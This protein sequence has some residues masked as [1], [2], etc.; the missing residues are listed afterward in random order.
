MTPRGRLDI[1]WADLASGA[2]ASLLPPSREALEWRV[3]NAWSEAADA[4]VCL[5]VRSGLDLLLSA[6]A[7]PR[8]SE[9]LVSAVTIRDMVR[10]I[11]HHGLVPVP[12]DLDM[13][14]L[15]VR[16]ESLE[17]ALRPQTKAVLV[18]HLF[19]S[20]MC[21]DAVAEFTRRH[22]LLL[23][24]DCAQSFT[25]LD[26]RGHPASDVTMFS[27]GPIKT[28]T[29]LGGAILGVRDRDLLAR[30]RALEAGY[31][32]QTRLQY[33]RR[34]C[35]FAFVKLLLS[36]AAFSLFYSACRLLGRSHDEVISRSVR[37]FSG[38]D[39]LA[40]IRRQPSSP[41]LA[42]LARRLARFDGTR[43]ARRTAAAE[44]FRKALPTLRLPG[45]CAAA[46]S[47][48][49][50]PVLSTAPDALVRHLWAQGFDATRGAWSLYAV[51]APEGCDRSAPE[52]GETMA[53]V[54]YLPV[55]PE[56]SDG[57]L[58]RLGRATSEFERSLA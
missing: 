40:S 31:P 42:L 8:G 25:G 17:R 9:I 33:L 12:V 28:C 58:A 1:S 56:V 49:T 27:F 13:S 53:Q 14:S 44:A 15:G 47:Y 50:F 7:Y 3:E 43:V 29:A 57:E 34:V 35:R 21:L 48:W 36:Q 54:V 4:L 16:V 19:G 5:S 41:L 46:H 22:G 20:R 45:R 18:A 10:V 52:A 26:Y 55:Y 23:L 30:M 37:G 6:L 24:E 32:I 39:F 38:P 2:A 11:E 51:P